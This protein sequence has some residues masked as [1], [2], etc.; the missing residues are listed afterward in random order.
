MGS[1]STSRFPKARIARFDTS[2]GRMQTFD[3]R[4]PSAEGEPGVLRTGQSLLETGAA[5]RLSSP[6]GES[7]RPAAGPAN[8]IGAWKLLDSMPYSFVIQEAHTKL[9][10]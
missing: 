4:D 3:R 8:E 5:R 1:R 7:A 6:P 2:T 9:Y 10:N